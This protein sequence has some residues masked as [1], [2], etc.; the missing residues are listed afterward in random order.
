M[1]PAFPCR[2]RVPAALFGSPIALQDL[3]TLYAGVTRYTTIDERFVAKGGHVTHCIITACLLACTTLHCPHVT[4]GRDRQS[5]G[6]PVLH[7][8]MSHPKHAPRRDCPSANMYHTG[9]GYHTNLAGASRGIRRTTP[10]VT[11]R[12][13][14]PSPPHPFIANTGE[15]AGPTLFCYC[16]H[17]HE[18]CRCTPWDR[19]ASP[20][21]L[22][23]PLRVR[24][25]LNRPWSNTTAE[26]NTALTTDHL[27][28]MWTPMLASTIR[29]HMA[30]TEPPHPSMWPDRIEE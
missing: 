21:G 18:L 10:S 8:S 22:Q 1:V 4:Q 23:A 16:I 28:S 2:Q 6:A 14:N 30:S 17:E 19:W 3:S 26:S 5:L 11:P 9:L 24:V 13:R 29:E 20:W 27:T 15:T 25:G 12:G 7:S